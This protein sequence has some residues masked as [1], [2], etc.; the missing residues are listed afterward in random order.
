MKLLAVDIG[1]SEIKWGVFEDEHLKFFKRLPSRGHDVQH[2]SSLLTLELSAMPPVNGAVYCGVVPWVEGGLHG[3]L[4]ENPQQI[5]GPIL[6]V[7]PELPFKGLQ[8]GDYPMHQL[9]AD[10]WVNAVSA[11]AEFSQEACIVFDFGTATNVD[12]V[13]AT[14]CYG[15][16]LITPGL[17]TFADSLANNTAQ[18]PALDHL[19]PPDVLGKNTTACLQSGIA[20]GYWGLI[21]E[22]VARIEAAHPEVRFRKVATG[23]LA[24]AA[25]QLVP[26]AETLFDTVDVNWTLKGLRH[27]FMQ[28]VATG[29]NAP[30]SA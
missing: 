28:A 26:N 4:A 24:Q 3:V 5:R 7:T 1:N 20:Y 2:L 15:G 10:R 19:T 23:G 17:R 21:K 30:Q 27:L 25:L 6:Q 29:E 11:W 22:L 8:L 12:V 18:L 9:G 13:F 14:G 16:G